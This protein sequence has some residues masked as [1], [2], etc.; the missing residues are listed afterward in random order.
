MA[1]QPDEEIQKAVAGFAAKY[2]L[3]GLMTALPTTPRFALQLLLCTPEGISI[4]LVAEY[5]GNLAGYINIYPDSE[6]GWIA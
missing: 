6:W 3:F 5:D 1:N 2:G 4:A